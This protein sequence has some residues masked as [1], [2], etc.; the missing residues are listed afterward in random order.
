MSD[1]FTSDLHFGHKQ[2]L[3]HCKETRPYSNVDEMNQ[4]LVDY[5]NDTV[6]EN[7]TIYHLGDFSFMNKT[8]TREILNQ[9]NG[10]KV[11]ILGN[12]DKHNKNLLKEYGV[13]EDYL[14]KSFVHNNTKHQIIMCHFPITYWDMCDHGSMHIFGHLHG[15]YKTNNRS[16]D[17]GWDAQGKFLKV[18]EIIEELEKFDPNK[19]R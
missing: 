16:M 5:W 2:I 11:F 10:N 18:T 13:T 3:K 6:S 7:D 9:L 1:F 15:D 8:R 12:H 19:R 4:A 14:R 17:V